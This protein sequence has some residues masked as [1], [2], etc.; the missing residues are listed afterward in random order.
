MDFG[1]IKSVVVSTNAD[2]ELPV[3]LAQV[4]IEGEDVVTVELPFAEGD[5][6]VPSVGDRIYY[7]EV[8]PEFLVAKCIQTKMPPDESLSE[9]GRELFSRNGSSRAAKVRLKSDGD[10]QLN[11]G[12]DFGVRFDALETAIR[13]MM[14]KIN[15]ALILIKAHTHT[16]TAPGVESAVSAGLVAMEVPVNIDMTEAK[17]P[18]VKL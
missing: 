4:Q 14:G 2:G 5:E 12:E 1:T 18:K 11:E 13:G 17:A 16:G 8:S 15:D 9:G 6:F 10:I 7:E 3:R